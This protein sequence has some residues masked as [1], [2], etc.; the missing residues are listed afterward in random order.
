MHILRSLV[1]AAAAGLSLS[2]APALAETRIFIIDN[3]D[4]YG[5]DACLSSGAP[6][7]EKIAAAWCHS[8]DYDH[9]LDFGRVTDTPLT[10]A[11]A[12]APERFCT[13]ALCPE[14]VAITC[15]R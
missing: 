6:C 4:G 10:P 1:F 14:A 12:R 11:S 15:A 7:G 13:G 3:S 5:V 9:A 2:V 8:H